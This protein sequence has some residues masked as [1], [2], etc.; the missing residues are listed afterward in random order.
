MTWNKLTYIK[1]KFQTSHSKINPA[2]WEYGTFLLKNMGQYG[3]FF[4]KKWDIMG[5]FAFEMGQLWDKNDSKIIKPKFLI[6][7]YIENLLPMHHEIGTYQQTNCLKKP[8]K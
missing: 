2:I 8:R 3:T 6:L 4:I 5:H 7:C 1:I